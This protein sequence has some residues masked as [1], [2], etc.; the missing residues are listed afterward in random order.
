[1]KR[2]DSAGAG[3]AVLDEGG[4]VDFTRLRTHRHRALAAMMAGHRL[5]ALVLG[6]EASIRYAS[7]ARRFWTEGAKPF[8]P[9]CVVI[10]D[11][12]SV[13]LL[14]TWDDGVPS[15]IGHAQ[16]Y[17]LTW[18]GAVLANELAGLPGLS[19][20]RRIGVDAMTPGA[21]RL[22]AGV[23]RNAEIVD[24]SGPLLDIRRIKTVD[25]QAC[26]RVAVAVAE[27]A[28]AYALTGLRPG[29]HGR[30]LTG[31]AVERMAGLGV[32]TPDLE[33]EFLPASPGGTGDGTI[34][35]GGLVTG[36]VG[37]L[38][39]GYEGVVART[40]V[41]GEADGRRPIPTVDQRK[42]SQ[43][44]QALIESLLAACHPGSTGADLVAAY[45]AVGEPL[46]A[47]PVAHGMGLGMEPPMIG[48]GFPAD[49]GSTAVLQAGMVLFVAGVVTH[50]E[51]GSIMAGETVLITESGP[52][53]LTTHGHGP[54]LDP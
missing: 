13:Y 50:P 38:Y 42:L 10:G 17:G 2:P 8:S 28:L 40:W 46:P 6:R 49:A 48:A 19:S 20:S 1:M 32:T 45:Q 27:S 22:L 3:T 18:N 33:P 29:I 25:E 44:W 39:A 5:D 11:S 14:S 12:A 26:I 43:R 16:L 15:E 41:N 24:I 51:A 23:A 34:P 35:A 4:R 31:R 37:V 47:S 7:G 30:E 54:A 53:L 36:Q 9:G 52:E 21:A